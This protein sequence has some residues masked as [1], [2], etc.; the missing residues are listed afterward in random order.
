MSSGVLGGGGGNALLGVDG[1]PA[2]LG[3]MSGNVDKP[4]PL[5]LDSEGRTV[6]STGREVQLTHVVPT[7]KANI[8][9]KKREEFKAQLQEKPADES[10]EAT[11]FDPRISLKPNVRNKKS[12]KFHEPGKFQQMA[13]RMRMKVMHLFIIYL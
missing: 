12:L 13:D 3:A 1:V 10:S 7:L 2:G 11:F 5:I 6:D 8:R 9:A 4:T